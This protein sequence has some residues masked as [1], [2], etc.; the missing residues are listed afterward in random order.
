MNTRF[1]VMCFLK[2]SQERAFKLF[3]DLGL[4]HVE[5]NPHQE[6]SSESST[7]ASLLFF[8]EELPDAEIIIKRTLPNF[9]VVFLVDT[10]KNISFLYKG[11]EVEEV[12][13]VEIPRFREVINKMG[14][15]V[16]LPSLQ[17]VQDLRILDQ[18]KKK[19]QSSWS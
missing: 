6:I 14:L 11:P 5:Q 9:T 2:A 4:D 18:N 8:F 1:I 7:N 17:N 10:V 16:S 12:V 19:I 15:D 3:A 13:S